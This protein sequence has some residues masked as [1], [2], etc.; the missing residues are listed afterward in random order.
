MVLLITN[1][2]LLLSQEKKLSIESLHTTHSCGA[3]DN[4]PLILVVSPVVISRKKAKHRE[5]TQ[6]LILVV[7]L[8]TNSF[9]LCYLKKKRKASRA[10][11]PLILVVLL[12]TNSVLL[13]SQEKRKASRAYTTTDSTSKA[14]TP[15][16]LVVLLITNPVL[17]LSQEK[18]LSIES[19]HTTH[20]CGAFDNQLIPVGISRKRGKHREST[21]QSFLWCFW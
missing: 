3:F 1:S 8:I 11:T 5:P 17:L 15:L 18:K 4:Q 19:L 12:I 2:V 16:I 9:L 14:Y 6:P 20:S 10:Y 7:L 13:L 21:H